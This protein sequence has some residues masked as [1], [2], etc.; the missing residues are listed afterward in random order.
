MRSLSQPVHRQPITRQVAAMTLPRVATASGMPNEDWIKVGVIR[1]TTTMPAVST[2]VAS[3]DTATPPAWPLS[4]R[5]IGNSADSACCWRMRVNTGVSSSQRRSHTETKPNTPPTT[6][7]MRQPQAS[8]SAGA[9]A[10]TTHEAISEPIKV[11]TLMPALRLP[12]AIPCARRAHARPRTPMPGIA[13]DRQPLQ[14]AQAQQQH[15][16]QRTDLRMDGQHANQQSRQR[17]QEDASENMRL[18]PMRSPKCAITT[19][20]SGRTR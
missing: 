15:R 2:H 12:T 4:T 10:C 18:R 7:A 16:R 5:L 1:I 20:P 17:H 3:I 14:H 6:K 11:P 8:T 9:K 19:P 13:A